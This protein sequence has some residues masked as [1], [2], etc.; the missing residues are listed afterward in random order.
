MNNE[1]IEKIDSV[2]NK[3]SD[4]ILNSKSLYNELRIDMVKALAELV[5]ARKND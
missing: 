4:D 1:T 2:I 3:L 5:S